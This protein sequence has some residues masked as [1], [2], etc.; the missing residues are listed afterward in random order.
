MII[1]AGYRI[2]PFEV[3]SALIEHAAVA[4]S[5]VVASPDEMRGAIVKA[6]VVLA[7]GYQPSSALAT[8]SRST[9]NNLTAPYK[10]PRDIEFVTDLPK[11]ISGKIRRVELRQREIAS[12][13]WWPAAP[14]VIECGRLLR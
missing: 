11:T 3:E 10:Y 7:P 12:K 6:F 5:A 1:S 4:E 13:A 14:G 8:S 2:G 9:S